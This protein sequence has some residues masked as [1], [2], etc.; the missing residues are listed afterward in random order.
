MET[1]RYQ[2]VTNRQQQETGKKLLGTPTI[3]IYEVKLGLAFR[4]DQA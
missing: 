2:Q 3:I 4:Y 1:Q